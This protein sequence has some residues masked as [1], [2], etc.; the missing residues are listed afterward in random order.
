MASAEDMRALL[1]RINGMDRALLEQ[2]ARADQATT[3]L[4]RSANGRGSSSRRCWRVSCRGHETTGQT[5]GIR[6]S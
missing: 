5:S 2:R 4:A 6:W 3:A 1:E